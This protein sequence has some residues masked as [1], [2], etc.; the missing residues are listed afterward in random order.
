M[1]DALFL[2]SKEVNKDLDRIAEGNKGG[3]QNM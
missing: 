3:G 2:I 1:E